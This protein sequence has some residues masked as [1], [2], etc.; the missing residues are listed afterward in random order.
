[1]ASE[2]PDLYYEIQALNAHT[3][4][5]GDWLRRSLED[6]LAALARGDRDGFVRMMTEARGTLDS[7]P[8]EAGSGPPD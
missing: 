7:L 8:R 5:A 4:A 6:W 3:T 1:V 2:N